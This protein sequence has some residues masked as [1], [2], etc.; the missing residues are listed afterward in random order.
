[1]PIEKPVAPYLSSFQE[2]LT[3]KV[4]S[5]VFTIE[6]TSRGGRSQAVLISQFCADIPG[7]VVKA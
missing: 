7:A 2:E 1:M 3:E 6:K 5:F 4:A